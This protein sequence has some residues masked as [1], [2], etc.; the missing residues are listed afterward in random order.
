MTIQ[1]REIFINEESKFQ[2]SNKM[3]SNQS[4]NQLREEYKSEISDNRSEIK[5]VN[6][7]NIERDDQL[8]NLT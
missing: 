4:S 2:R 3:I 7:L 8:Q 1:K 6:M 5:S